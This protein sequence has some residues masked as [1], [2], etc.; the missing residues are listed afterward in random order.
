MFKLGAHSFDGL[1][2]AYLSTMVLSSYG[3]VQFG[4][5]AVSLLSVQRTGR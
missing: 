1:E 5:T 2:K 3:L 4:E